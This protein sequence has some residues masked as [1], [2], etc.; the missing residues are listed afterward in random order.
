[1]EDDIRKILEVAVNAP[2]GSNSQ[3][4]KFG[5]H[6]NQIEVIAM[7][8]RDH[9]VLNFRNRGTWIAH[10]ALLEN[11]LIASSHNGYKASVK[12]F[13]EKSE[14]NITARISLEKA[15]PKN[16]PLYAAISLRATNRKPYAVTPLTSEQKSK[17]ITS[18]EEVGGG[19]E[20]KLVED[21]EKIKI[22]GEAGAANE[23]VTLEN[24]TLHKLFFNE[25]VWTRE[26]ER[27]R[28]KGLYL[29]TME[30]K[31]PQAAMLKLFR[32]WKIMS[33]FNKI[34]FAR[35]IAKGNAKN[36]AS[37][38]LMGAIMVNDRDEDFITAGRLMERLWLKATS[39][40]LSFH[41]I[42]GVLFFHQVIQS[43]KKDQFS[44]EQIRIVENAYRSTAEIFEAKD[45]LVAIMFRIGKDGEPSARST[46]LP[47]E[48]IFEN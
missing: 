45:K 11:I 19:V 39:W 25:I 6:G 28:K 29:K 22:L 15:S 9:P 43:G 17:L 27:E 31:P 32:N 35:A 36:Y 3:P 34:K 12:I 46:K 13:P 16:E 48:I 4:W 44:E 18:A 26:E 2:S 1:M 8:E 10:G 37:T 14:P 5:V 24:K 30:L 33:F 20:L 40:G 41:I 21:P 23:I 38:P 47:P 7:P 42:T